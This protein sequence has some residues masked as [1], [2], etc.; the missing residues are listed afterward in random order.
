MAPR[1]PQDEGRL[2]PV[3]CEV[4]TARTLPALSLGCQH[5]LAPNLPFLHHLC[6]HPG[7]LPMWPPLPELSSQGLVSQQ[8]HCSLQDLLVAAPP[9]PVFFS[10]SLMAP[11]L[12]ALL[13]LAIVFGQGPSV[14]L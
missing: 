14:V 5:T 1:W 7:P 13:E 9:L 6:L 12:T 8:P 4:S 3:A 10:L 2:L 11:S